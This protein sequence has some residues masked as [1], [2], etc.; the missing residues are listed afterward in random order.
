MILVARPLN[1]WVCMKM[2][3]THLP[4]LQT[5]IRYDSSS[6]FHCQGSGISNLSWG[7]PYIFPFFYYYS[8]R[9]FWIFFHFV[10]LQEVEVNLIIT[11]YCMP[12]MTGYDLLKK[13]KVWFSLY[14]LVFFLSFFYPSFFLKLS[15]L[16][17]FLSLRRVDMEWL[18]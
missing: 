14:S 1:F 5:V 11:D 3:Q 15:H 13:I 18:S 12:G 2:T 10:N 16:D 8:F 17:N 9:V 6:F 7:F 4:F